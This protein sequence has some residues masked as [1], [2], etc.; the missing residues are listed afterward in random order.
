M[1]LVS[2]P[3]DG[4]EKGEVNFKSESDP[5][6]RGSPRLTKPETK[7]LKTGSRYTLGRKD[8]QLVVN[9]AKVSH[10][11]GALTVGTYS[12]DDVVSGI[13][14]IAASAYLPV[15]LQS[16]P[17]VVPTLSIHNAGKKTMVLKR[18]E[19]SIIIAPSSTE[20]LQDGDIVDVITGVPL[21]FSSLPCS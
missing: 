20:D 17:S 15:P 18:G 7:L 16:D 13:T 2:G 12:Q 19:D 8:R 6:S 3:F 11:H 1:W 9:H 21:R 14:V 5:I 10:D 4:I